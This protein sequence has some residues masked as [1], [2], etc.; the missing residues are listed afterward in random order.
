[1]RFRSSTERELGLGSDAHVMASR[2]SLDR[3]TNGEGVPP[4]FHVDPPVTCSHSVE[5]ADE[6][7]E[8][9][10]CDVRRRCPHV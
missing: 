1:M 5:G 3:P 6:I 9:Q 8:G 4:V 2:H 7:D 10:G